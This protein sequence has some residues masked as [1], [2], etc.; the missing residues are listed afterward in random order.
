MKD[1]FL[2][3]VHNCVQEF[4]K[5][6]S[7]DEYI[8]KKV[9]DKYFDDYSDIIS[10]SSKYNEIDD[11]EYK[12]LIKIIN[13]GY[14]IIE[15]KNLQYVSKHLVKDKEYFDDIFK[16]VDPN[17]SLDEEQRKAILIDEDYSLIVAGAGS[18]KTTTMAAKVKYL[19]EKKNIDPKSIILLSF[20]NSS[21]NDLNDL[22]N[23][24]FG[25]GV[26]VLTF[27]KLGM[28]FL[29]ETFNQK[30]EIISDAGINSVISEYF[31]N[32]VFKNKERLKDYRELFS[33][34]LIL[35][36]ECLEY[37]SYDDYYKNYMDRKYEISKD[38]LANE[39]LRRKESRKRFF[40]TINGEIVK[41]IGELNI[42]N[43]LYLNGINYKYEQLYPFV[44]N[45]NRSYKPDFT[46][47]NFDTP[48]YVE[49]YGLATIINNNIES[50]S[51][52]YKNEIFIKRATH[53]KNRTD[54]IELY[55]ST[56]NENKIIERLDIELK[57][58]NVPMRKRT[59]KEVFYRLLETSKTF[60]YTRLIK[61]FGLFINVFKEKNLN[62]N[63][64]DKLIFECS[65][66]C[67]KRQLKYIKN[68]YSYYQTTIH[69]QY[70]IDFQDMI[71]YAFTNMESLQK[72]NKNVNYNYVLIDEYQDISY[73]RYSFSKKISDLFNAKIVA[74]GDD[75]QAIYSFSG[76]DIELFT[77][78]G[79]LLG[80]DAEIKI[81][82]TYRNSQELINLAG[83]FILKDN[84]QIEKKLH[85]NK[86]LYKP[87]KIVEYEYNEYCDNLANRVEEII[88]QLYSLYPND[89]ILL[90]S[91]FNSDIDNLINSGLFC[92]KS[93][94]DFRVIC[95]KVPKCKIDFMTVHKSKGLGYD[96]V[97]LLNGI[98]G[99]YGFPS[100]I[101]DEPVIK[102]LK[103]DF[104]L[105]DNFQNCIE[106]PEE[107]RLFY[108]AITR[109]KNELYIM[110]PSLYELKSDFIKEI[111]NHSEAIKLKET[112][113]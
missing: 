72:H 97:I 27:H 45:G 104:N 11:K 79:E 55:D 46:I 48:I 25:L 8:S 40:K 42:A 19:I 89:N 7:S 57:A 54:L 30:F 65:D 47:M 83:D 61:L 17:I 67:I 95:K 26:E 31:L 100:Q 39:I 21:V 71:H 4:Y 9:I 112:N 63:D 29:R 92:R 78:F 18:G 113:R 60:P 50:D 99:T 16:D 93:S 14:E 35:D 43:Y 3:Q 90:L 111:E 33:K 24:K 23:N 77:K 106:Y 87:V 68:V 37:D 56:W 52:K 49:F 98:N 5:I 36:D 102:Y 41:S 109:T 96:R 107:R 66:D 6:Y 84:M 75:W 22:I 53:R 2:E 101:K 59:S 44:L 51:D 85:S 82:N 13:Y 91:R 64:F 1:L 69:Q 105:N 76:S 86:H 94:I 74:V 32:N 38:D 58:R 108:V 80:Y 12:K 34:Y 110:S 28:K 103:G 62:L 88:I 10:L 81:T 70:K 73:Q 20:T 15:N